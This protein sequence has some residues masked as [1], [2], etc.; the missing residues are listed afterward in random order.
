MEGGASGSLAFDSRLVPGSLSGRGGR[1]AVKN[2]H[3]VEGQ[4]VEDLDTA[5]VE[6]QSQT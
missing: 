4:T 6:R 5:V 1:R 2:T 3:S